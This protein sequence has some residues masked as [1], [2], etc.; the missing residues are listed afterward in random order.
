MRLDEEPTEEERAAELLRCDMSYDDIYEDDPDDRDYPDNPEAEK[1]R[2]KGPG[3]WL[4][5]PEAINGIEDMLADL[6]KKSLSLQEKERLHR[7]KTAL[8]I[9]DDDALWIVIIALEYHLPCMRRFREK[10]RKRWTIF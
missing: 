3:K 8:K 6:R 9:P 5:A 4:G 2:F 10:S 1:Y 7:V